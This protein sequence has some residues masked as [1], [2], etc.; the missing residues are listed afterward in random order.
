VKVVTV[1]ANTNRSA[2]RQGIADRGQYMA[3][4]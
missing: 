1:T 2:A 4:M 3:A